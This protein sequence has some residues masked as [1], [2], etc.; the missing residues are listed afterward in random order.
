MVYMYMSTFPL[1]NHVA[2]TSIPAVVRRVKESLPARNGSL[3]RP[4]LHSVR[5]VPLI[6]QCIEADY[7]VRLNCETKGSD[8]HSS[9][10]LKPA[11]RI[12]ARRYTKSNSSHLGV[13]LMQCERRL[14][15][16][17]QKL[18]HQPLQSHACRSLAVCTPE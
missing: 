7:Y 16:I 15:S 2:Y 6:K 10:N 8:F 17:I 14:S 13:V 1:T 9:Y 4:A 11:N 18:S 3:Y 5:S 12:A